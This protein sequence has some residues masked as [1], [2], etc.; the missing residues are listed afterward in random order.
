MR[1]FPEFYTWHHMYKNPKDAFKCF[2][3]EVAAHRNDLLNFG[4]KVED[5]YLDVEDFL[6]KLREGGKFLQSYPGRHI[7]N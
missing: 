7:N 4:I 5:S 6:A 3:D 1:N 2:I